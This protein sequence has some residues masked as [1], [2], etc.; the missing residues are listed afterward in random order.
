[1]PHEGKRVLFTTC[2]SN[3]AR[4]QTL[5]HVARET[6]RELCI[7]G[8]SLERILA[9][10][11]DNGYLQD[12]PEPVD[13]GTAMSLP[14]G[15]VLILATGGQGEPRAALA[16]IAEEQHPLSLTEGDV[17]LFSSRQIPGNE[18]AI[19]RVQNLL[20]YRGITMITDR[21]SM[22]HV[23]GPPGRPDLEAIY[24]GLRPQTRSEERSVG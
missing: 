20:A 13:F 11:Q 19:G 23:S 10:S 24:S 22:L 1:M 9:V 2:A 16:R 7:A 12:F 14:R 21:Q 15:K 18:L 3:V 6:G 5:G 17:V 4:L 8:R